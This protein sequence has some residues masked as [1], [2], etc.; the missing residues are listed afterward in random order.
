MKL[1]LIVCTFFCLSASSVLGPDTASQIVCGAMQETEQSGEAEKAKVQQEKKDEDEERDDPVVMVQNEDPL[2]VA[3]IEE[4]RKTADDFIKELEKPSAGTD[5][6]SFAI[7][8][9]VKDGERVEHMWLVAVEFQDGKFVGSINNEPRIVKNVK[10]GQGYTIAKNEISDWMYFKKGELQGAFTLRA[11]QEI[12]RRPVK[13]IPNH[14][15]LGDWKLI[16]VRSADGGQAVSGFRATVTETEMTM[17]D[18]DGERQNFGN[19]LKVDAESKP[20]QIDL[21]DDSGTL[22]GLFEING[23]R[24]RFIINPPN[25]VRPTDF[26]VEDS[27]ALLFEFRREAEKKEDK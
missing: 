11:I 5:P 25:E 15:L 26:E 16:R 13:P 14:A 4:A 9:P 24:M 6:D 18:P 12:Q 17:I 20:G 10:F 23:R 7:K 2:M 22:L 3:A 21:R 1:F 8:V 19:L 27:S